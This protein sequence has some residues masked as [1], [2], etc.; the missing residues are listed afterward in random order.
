MRVCV[1]VGECTI[2]ESVDSLV[3]HTVDKQSSVTLCV[4]V[5]SMQVCVCVYMH[6]CMCVCVCACVYV[7]VCAQMYNTSVGSLV[8]HFLR[9]SSCQSLCVCVCVCV[10]VAYSHTHTH[11][12]THTHSYKHTHT[13]TYAKKLTPHK[14][15]PT[16]THS[17]EK[18]M[19]NL[20][21][22]KLQDQWFTI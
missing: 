4:C 17:G 2:P 9:V 7:C 13:H 10:F 15:A 18:W 8:G 3:G 16:L 6:A 12:R 20:A 14:Y 21:E 19:K 1:C 5:V 22:Q 11:M